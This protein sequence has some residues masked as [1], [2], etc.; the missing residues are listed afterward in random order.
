MPASGDA[1]QWLAQSATGSA[2]F[3]SVDRM[4]ENPYKSPES[5]AK[6]AADERP[7][8]PAWRRIVSLPLIVFGAVF[9]PVGLLGMIIKS[10]REGFTLFTYFECVL[11]MV[12]CFG[13]LCGGIILRL[14]RD[15][16]A[17]KQFDN[18]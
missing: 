7:L 18:S 6:P 9:L 2:A 11:L 4:S 1:R 14:P 17:G 16:A 13:L 10:N 8:L 3:L 5:E 12:I 15:E